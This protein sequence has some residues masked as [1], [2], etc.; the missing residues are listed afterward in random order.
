MNKIG[1]IAFLFCVGCASTPPNQ[2]S[3]DMHADAVM[4]GCHTPLGFIPEGHTATGYLN[5]LAQGG[6]PC[7]QGTLSCE[8][9]VWS[10]PYI[11]PSCTVLP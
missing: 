7:Q 4:E 8:D 6:Q 1:W 2:S 11:Y 3:T 10:G 9:G 5:Q